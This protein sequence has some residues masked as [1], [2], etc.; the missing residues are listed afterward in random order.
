MKELFSRLEVLS[1][2]INQASDSLSTTINQIEI[3]LCELRLG[4]EAWVHIETQQLCD[5]EGH[6]DGSADEFLGY[7][8]Y[9][10]KWQLLTKARAFKQT[11]VILKDTPDENLVGVETKPFPL[12]QQN[13]EQ[14]VKAL[15]HLPALLAELAKSAE[16]TLSMIESQK[17]I[18]EAVVDE[19]RLKKRT[20]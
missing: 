18:A 7:A 11:E 20:H 9:N 4:V 8:K 15:Q 6:A 10:G 3:K 16:N 13:R 1:A 5:D 14:R 2:R 12:C 19:L 17:A